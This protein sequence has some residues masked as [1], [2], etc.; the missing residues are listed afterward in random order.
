MK[1]LQLEANTKAVA[2]SCAVA[3]EVAN[4]LSR[5]QHHSEINNADVQQSRCAVA[6]VTSA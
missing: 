1:L 6:H 2:E 4:S 3:K 5:Y